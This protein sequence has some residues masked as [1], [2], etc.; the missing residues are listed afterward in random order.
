M[1]DACTPDGV[2]LV[3]WIRRGRIAVATGHGML[4]VTLAPITGQILAE[5]FDGAETRFGR[6]LSPDRFRSWAATR[7]SRLRRRWVTS[8]PCGVGDGVMDV[9]SAILINQTSD[10]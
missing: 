6:E 2:P 8:S 7:G 1:I 9:P 4:G 10:P 5:L 3:G